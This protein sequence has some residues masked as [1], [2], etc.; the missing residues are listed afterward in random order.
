MPRLPD[1]LR[2]EVGQVEHRPDCPGPRIVRRDGTRA[3]QLTCTACEA[4]VCVTRRTEW[5][6]K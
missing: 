1:E 2:P 6:D 4:Y 5:R 3:A